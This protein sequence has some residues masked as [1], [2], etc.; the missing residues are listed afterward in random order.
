MKDIFQKIHDNFQ[1]IICPLHLLF[2]FFKL[3]TWLFRLSCFDQLK[4]RKADG[5]V[6][7]TLR[8]NA[9]HPLHH[10]PDDDDGAGAEESEVSSELDPSGVTGAL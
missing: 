2:R 4:I 10:S 7:V 9:D 6:S 1:K 5:D 3:E 8:W